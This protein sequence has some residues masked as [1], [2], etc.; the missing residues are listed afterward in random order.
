MASWDY[1]VFESLALKHSGIEQ[2]EKLKSPLYSIFWK[3]MLASYHADESK[4]L[5]RSFLSEESI[6]GSEEEMVQVVK[7]FF[8][9]LTGSEKDKINFKEAL[10]LSE[11]HIIAYAQS[12]HSI[13][14]ILAQVIYIGIN[15]ENTLSKPI[16]ENNRYLKYINNCMRN[17]GFA[18]NIVNSID[19][20]LNLSEFQYL[21]AY[22]NTTKHQSLIEVNHRISFDT[23]KYGILIH[24]FVYKGNPYSEKWAN[25]FV[26]QDFQTIKN[27]IIF[28]GNELNKHLENT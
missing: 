28:V 14:D 15:L 1:K 11:A 6:E 16:V 10:I 9:S 4:R 20:L 18:S 3:L 8:L 26:I 12:L 21:Q 2:F 5:Y 22:D 23:S 24:P 17:I 13:S 7:H 25:N 27:N 19:T